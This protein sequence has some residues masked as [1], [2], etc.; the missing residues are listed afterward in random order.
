MKILS[1]IILFF[2]TQILLAQSLDLQRVEMGTKV[3]RRLAAGT[4]QV[5][6]VHA[7]IFEEDNGYI[8]S[9]DSHRV[10]SF[11]IYLLERAMLLDF[12]VYPN[13]SDGNM[14]LNIVAAAAGYFE[15]IITDG[16]GTILYQETIKIQTGENNI[17]L[18][19]SSFEKGIYYLRLENGKHRE[20]ETIIIQ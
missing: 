5:G 17:Q 14:Q 15:L 16:F 13:P 12:V 4:Q 2:S 20:F 8:L 1:A 10:D 11:D 19:L 18:N 3:E 6:A 7:A 9:L